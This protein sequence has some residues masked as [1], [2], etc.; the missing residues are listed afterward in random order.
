MIRIFLKDK[1]LNIKDW[2]MYFDEKEELMVIVIYASGKKYFSPYSEFRIEPTTRKTEDLLYDIN[3]NK[4]SNICNAIEVGEKY[5]LVNYKQGERLYLYSKER[6]K[7]LKSTNITKCEMFHYFKRIAKERVSIAEKENERIIAENIVSQFDKIIPCEKTALNSYI[8]GKLIENNGTI[9]LIYPFGVNETQMAAVKN[10]FQSQISIVEGPPGTG[11]TQTILNIIAN[12]VVSGKNC[13]IVSNNNSAVENVYEKMEK[14]GLGSLIAKLGNSHNKENFFRSISYDKPAC[15]D[16]LIDKDDIKNILD[17]VEEYLHV[18][19]DLAKLQLEIQ[20]IEIEKKYLE[21]WLLKYPEIEAHYIDKYNLDCTKTIDLFAYIKHIE[22]RKLTFKDKWNLLFDYKIFKNKFLNN[23][24]N[25]ESFIF[26]LQYTFYEKLLDKKQKKMNEKEKI[27]EEND[28]NH[29][30]NLLKEKS[31]IFLKQYVYRNMSNSISNFSVEN[32]KKKFS[33]FLKNFPVIGSSSHSLISSIGEGYLLDYVIIDEASQQ[34]LVPGVLCLACAKNIIVVG[35][36]K[37]LSHIA[38]ETNI[39]VPNELYDC[40]KYS[41]LDS[42]S[43]VFGKYVPRTLLKEHY[44]CHPKIIQFCNKQFYNEELIPMTIDKGEKA[45]ELIITSLGNHMRNYSNQREIESV[46]KIN[47]ENF[48]WEK[49]SEDG[50]TIGFITPYNNQVKLAEKML[51]KQIVE[52]TIHKFQGREC[53]EVVFSTVLDKKIISQRQLD[54]VDNPELVNVAVSRARNKFTLVTGRD[55]F[56]NSS[57]YIEALVRYIEYYGEEDAI[58]DKPVISAF[59]LLYSE[60]DSSLEKLAKK[61]NKNDNKIKSE[62]IVSA[63][64]RTI[65]SKSEFEMLMVHEQIYLKQL[66]MCNDKGIFNEREKQ[67]IK[68]RASCDFVVYYKIGKKPLA[69]VEVDGAFHG[70]E[71]Q[72]ERD[73]VK[74]NI[75]NK[76]KYSYT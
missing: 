4:Y 66:I 64:F 40:Q 52:N 70:T 18:S 73:R 8:Y 50:H 2:K 1:L 63:L 19:N 76:V 35:D 20:E 37:Q 17:K 54:F 12:I 68:N 3:N 29:N 60:Y 7:L 14:V 23:I 41:L 39:S 28:Y 26:S 30:I 42:V 31:M 24:E 44:R 62:Q 13:A 5:F 6:Y 69:V 27:L 75:L 61:L 49:D 21:K 57:G 36:R 71:I 34:D 47:K 48:F 72:K 10:A 67:F 22:D 74:D 32:H 56:K 53:D 58:Y 9:D 45:L 46:I 25:R 51:P 33:G 43:E 15:V 55:V 11:K 16:E 38:I 65:L 59:D